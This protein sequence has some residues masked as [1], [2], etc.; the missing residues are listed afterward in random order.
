MESYVKIKTSKTDYL[1]KSGTTLLQLSQK[2]QVNHASPIMAARVNNELRPLSDILKQD[3]EIEFIDRSHDDGLRIYVRSLTMLFIRACK[4]LFP[5]CEVSVEHSL[6]KGLYCEFKDEIALS[7]KLVS[8]I[9]SRMREIAA[10]REPFERFEADVNDAQSIL[11]S[12]GFSDKAELLRY[13]EEKTIP[14]YRFGWLTDC[15]YGYMVPDAGYLDIFELKFYL[16]GLILRFPTKLTPDSL[17]VLEDNPKLYSVFRESEEWAQRVNVANVVQLNR[18]IET[19]YGQDLVH[20]SEALHEKQIA[21]IADKIS[22]QRQK[23]HLILIA[24]PSASGK[25]TF[26]QRLKIHLMVNGLNPIPISMDNY[27]LDRDS[28]PLDEEGQRDLEAISTI[29]IELLNE[30]LSKLIQGQQVELPFFN[31]KKGVRE[32]RGN[33]ISINDQQPLIIEGIHGLNEQL[34]PMIPKMNKYKIYIS[35]LTQLNLDSHNRI[36]TTDTRLIRRIVRDRQFRGASIGDTLTM[37][38]SV[39]R[40]EEKYIFPYQE[41]ADVMFNSALTYEM[42]VLKPFIMPVLSNIDTAD[43]YFIEANRLKKFMKYFV[44]MDAT[45]IPATSIIKEFIGGSSLQTGH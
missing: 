27:Y 7:P 39:R 34:T 23:I 26:A 42:A 32:Y 2:H 38:P 10:S 18:K 15:L 14:L 30:H 20:I 1:E 3:C 40:G 13:R 16:P 17:P 35:A 24:G 28:I 4:E 43:P 6:N 25:T 37:W 8:R 12:M 33:L 22:A 45:N 9:E 5:N 11:K 41:M 29:D 31:F 44:E 19:G 36:P 21:G